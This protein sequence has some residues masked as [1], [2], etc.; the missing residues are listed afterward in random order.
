MKG[1]DFLCVALSPTA[2]SCAVKRDDNHVLFALLLRLLSNPL[3]SCF[4]APQ[5]RVVANRCKLCC[6]FYALF[7]T[8]G[9]SICYA[10]CSN[11]K[12]TVAYKVESF[13]FFFLSF[14]HS[15]SAFLCHHFGFWL[16]SARDFI[17]VIRKYTPASRS[18]PPLK[19][20]ATML[21]PSQTH[22]AVACKLL[23][24]LKAAMCECVCVRSSVCIL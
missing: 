5:S 12:S 24:S 21:R 3:S 6:Y 22:A 15:F 4:V 13:F 18:L 20:A 9:V 8:L 2:A 11:F 23:P 14:C 7:L 10:L 1:E 16:S 17:S 19:V